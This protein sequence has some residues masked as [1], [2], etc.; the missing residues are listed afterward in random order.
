MS[1]YYSGLCSVGN[2]FGFL[3][4]SHELI[5]VKPNGFL[6]IDAVVTLLH[7]NLQLLLTVVES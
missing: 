4:I 2:H 1:H 5:T 3:P 7:R 6:I